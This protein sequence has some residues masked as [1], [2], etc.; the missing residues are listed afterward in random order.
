LSSV[1]STV[2]AGRRPV[3][4]LLT[5]T[6]IEADLAATADVAPE[7]APVPRDDAPERGMPNN[8]Y[9]LDSRLTAT[10]KREKEEEKKK[11]KCYKRFRK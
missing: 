6:R 2:G 8:E 5:L 11:K 1:K 9:S 3:S 10:K 4:D 7:P